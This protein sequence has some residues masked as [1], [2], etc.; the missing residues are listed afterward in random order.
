MEKISVELPSL[1]DRVLTYR[2][3]LKL[4]EQIVT[5]EIS[6]FPGSPSEVK[7]RLSDT[8]SRLENW[9]EDCRKQGG[10]LPGSTGVQ[11][12]IEMIRQKLA[13]G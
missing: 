1:F 5:D 9:L 10:P 3:H 11:K 4:V 7:H 8:K 6:S 13:E 2:G 12:A